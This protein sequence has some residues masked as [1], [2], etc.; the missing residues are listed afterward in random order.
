MLVGGA[1][2]ALWA[3]VAMAALGT[4]RHEWRAGGAGA[5]TGVVSVG[6]LPFVVVTSEDVTVTGVRGPGF[7]RRWE[8]RPVV[9]AGDAVLMAVLAAGL[10][11]VH[12]WTVDRWRLERWCD[13]CGY[14]L[15]AR[16]TRPAPCPECGAAVSPA[17]ADDPAAA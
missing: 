6:A 3:L 4:A 8:W 12:R 17:P 5:G 10:A 14:D 11:R 15:R 1:L 7:T 9:L 16:P 2:A 13:E